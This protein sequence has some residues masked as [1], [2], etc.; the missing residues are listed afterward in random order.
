MSGM[1]EQAERNW[2]ARREGIEPLSAG[3]RWAWWPKTLGKDK[4]K[5]A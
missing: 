5:A 1:W 3:E 4:R 2:V